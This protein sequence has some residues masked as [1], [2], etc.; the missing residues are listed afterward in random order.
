MNKE[1]KLTAFWLAV[2]I[3]IINPA[4]S[5]VMNMIYGWY[6]MLSSGL[7]AT[8]NIVGAGALIVHIIIGVLFVV[9]LIE[10]YENKETKE[11]QKKR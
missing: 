11:L 1:T 5:W 10:H 6:S 2:Y 7:N 8:D 4:T 3:F 9:I